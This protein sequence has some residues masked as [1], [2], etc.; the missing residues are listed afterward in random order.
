MGID[1]TKIESELAWGSSSKGVC[2]FL[3]LAGHQQKLQATSFRNDKPL[4]QPRH[5]ILVQEQQQIH[6]S[7][8]N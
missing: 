8:S 7:T 3:H 6:V 5:M 4:C 2:Q 1:G